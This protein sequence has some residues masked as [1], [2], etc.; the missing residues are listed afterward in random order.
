MLP[1]T[2]ERASCRPPLPI[3]PV[4]RRGPSLPV[5]ISGKSVKISPFTVSARTSAERLGGRSSVMPP[6]TVRNSTPFV[7]LA[8]P[9]AA[10]IDPFTVVASETR[11][12]HFSV[13]RLA[14]EPHP[15]GHVHRELHHDVV[16]VRAHVPALAGPA[17]VRPA[18]VARIHRADRD[19]A[20][21][22][23]DLDLHFVG[24]AAL[25]AL[26]R[27][28]LGLAAGCGDRPHVAV[29]APDLDLFAGRD[30]A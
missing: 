2:V 22:L 4:T 13:H 23:E 3:V 12:F 5:T 30:L 14:D 18:A 26:R 17:L 16:L 9:I 7:Q 21:V 10:T 15:S 29:H 25:G 27:G 19:A 28:D 11:R 6:F 20:F 8:F 24:V 1:L